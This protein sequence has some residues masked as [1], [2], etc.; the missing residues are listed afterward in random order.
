MVCFYVVRQLETVQ[1]RIV[2][3]LKICLFRKITQNY[4]F[5][6]EFQNKKRFFFEIVITLSPFDDKL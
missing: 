2:L 1:N 5:F 3:L 6:F 4:T